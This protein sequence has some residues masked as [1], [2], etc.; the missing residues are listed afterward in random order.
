MLPQ[1]KKLY[2]EI[3]PPIIEKQKTIDP[4]DCSVYQLLEQYVEWEKDNPLA[5]NATVKA[6]ALVLQKIFFPTYLEHLAFVIIRAGWKVTKMHSHLR[7]D[8]NLSKKILF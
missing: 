6:H 1:N 7:F 4:C 8:K 5:Y 2:N 3:Y